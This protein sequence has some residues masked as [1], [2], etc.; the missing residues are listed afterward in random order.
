MRADHYILDERGEPVVA[1][2]VV[3]WAKWKSSP[4]G[5]A[6]CRIAWTVIVDGRAIQVLPDPDTSGED[7]VTAATRAAVTLDPD[8][9]SVNRGHTVVSTVFL[10]LDHNFG[11]GPPVLWETMLFGHTDERGVGFSEHQWRA[12]SRAEALMCHAHA[13]RVA[14]GEADPDDEPVA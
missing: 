11:F 14:L 2:D 3:A 6:A 10:G 8:A 9:H 7:E 13:V 12:S 4:E 1:D 5:T